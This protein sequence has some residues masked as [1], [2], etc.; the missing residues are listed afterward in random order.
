MK[1]LLVLMMIF[2]PFFA[3]FANGEAVV[4]KP[5]PDF[6]AKDAAGKMHQLADY[7]GKWVVLEW[8]N[9]DCPYVKKHYSVGNM[10]NIQKKYTDKGVAWLTV[11]SGAKGK[12]GHLDPAATLTHTK[13][14]KANAT[15]YLIDETGAIGKAYGAK[16]TPHMFI[17]NPAGV[18]V[19][20]GA[21]DSNDSADSSVI[22]QSTNYVSAALDAGLLGK[23]IEKVSTKPYG[24][25]VKY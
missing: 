20:A 18:V 14:V 11:N 16:T 13:S 24:C 6:S 25:S 2:A 15:A 19:Y 21:I 10:Q 7:K 8:Y 5:A 1:K 17:I 3:N 23:S 9:K 22:P 4:Q 12:Q